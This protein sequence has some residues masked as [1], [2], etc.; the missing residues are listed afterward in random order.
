MMLINGDCI[1]ELKKIEDNSIDSVVTDPPYGLSKHSQEEV[2]NC[3][4]AWISGVPYEPKG[5][6]FM[7]KLWD[8]WVPGPEVWKEVVRIV[9]P[10]G[11]ALVFA[12]TRSMDLMCMG[13][14]LT[15]FDLRDNQVSYSWAGGSE[16]KNSWTTELT[17]VEKLGDDL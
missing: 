15:G 10:G 14:R 9:K 6:G 4:T 8:A 16:C 13:L 17:N 7:S 1:E 2:V 5:K 11:H 12:G 3:L